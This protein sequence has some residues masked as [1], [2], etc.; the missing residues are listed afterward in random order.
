MLLKEYKFN[1]IV[2]CD[3][4]FFSSVKIVK[5]VSV[6]HICPLVELRKDDTRTFHSNPASPKCLTSV[7]ID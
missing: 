1:S 3:F 4:H 2:K 6:L 7:V 5:L